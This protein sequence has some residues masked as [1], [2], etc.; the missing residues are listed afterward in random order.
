MVTALKQTRDP[1][2][3]G[4]TMLD[5]TLVVWTRDI[6]NG[7]D[8]TQAKMPFVLAGA[9]SYLKYSPSGGT[10]YDL[11]SSGGTTLNMLLTMIDAMGAPIGNFASTSG[12]AQTEK[13]LSAIKA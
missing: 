9:T 1:S 2:G 4:K 3:S 10:Y 11:S 13:P 7:P 5:D 6:G 12:G 8:H